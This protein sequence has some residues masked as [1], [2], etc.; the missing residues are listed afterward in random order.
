MVSLRML[1][2]FR[3]YF[4]IGGEKKMSELYRGFEFYKKVQGTKYDNKDNETK[5]KLQKFYQNLGEFTDKIF[6]A[7]IPTGKGLW[8][9]SGNYSKYL[10]NRY[11]P[12]ENSSNLV[13]YFNA[14]AR[15][16]TLFVSIGLVDDR[17]TEYE[18]EIKDKIYNF[19]SNECEKI[20]VDGFIRKDFGWGDRVFIIEDEESFETLDYSELLE[21]LKE[22][23]I[24]TYEKFYKN[25]NEN[26][27]IK[28][29]TAEKE[30]HTMQT[31]ALN[32]ILFGSPG[33]G[34]TYNTINK[35]LEIILEK[36]NSEENKIILEIL[37]KENHTLDD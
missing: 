29:E 22:I 6:S 10:W 35:A 32:Q 1:G 31:Q 34:K 12:F 5:E 8:Q 11:K 27:K 14:S 7:Y 15:E 20:V 25:S 18:K 2:F 23:Y 9:N 21:N 36:D 4:T 24:K 30:N 17:L 13:M 28:N 26:S 19:L 16:N 37:R 3:K 33:T